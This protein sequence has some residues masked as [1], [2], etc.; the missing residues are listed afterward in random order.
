MWNLS[1]APATFALSLPTLG[2]IVA[3]RTTHVET[4]LL[5]LPADAGWV[6]DGLAKQQ[7]HV[8]DQARAHAQRN[9]AQRAGPGARDARVAEPRRALAG[10]APATIEFRM[11]ERGRVRVRV[12]D[13]RGAACVRC[14]TT[15]WRPATSELAWD[16]HAANGARARAGVYFVVAECGDERTLQ[17]LALL[18]RC[19]GTRTAARAYA[20]GRRARRNQRA[21]AG[22][23]ALVRA[24]S[25]IAANA[26]SRS[27][28]RSAGS[29]MPTE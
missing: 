18:G 16:G 21:A 7:P 3:T 15:C 25:G 12:L 4:D 2:D 23:A 19:A 22:S 20:G 24:C 11:R 26:C 1:N 8:P 6:S 28:M 29:S 17:E 10:A 27:A 13:V 14:A 5:A 9:P